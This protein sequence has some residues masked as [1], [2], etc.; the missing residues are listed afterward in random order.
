[1]LDIE[2]PPIFS[3][4][5]INGRLTFDPEKNIHLQAYQIFVQGGQLFVGTPEEPFVGD[6]Q[7]TLHGASTDATLLMTGALEAGNKI[8]ASTGTVSM[9]GQ[10][11]SRMSRLHGEIFAG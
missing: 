7:I 2:D 5:R 10:H 6:A 3:M 4:V 8:F 1:M 11:R 9:Y